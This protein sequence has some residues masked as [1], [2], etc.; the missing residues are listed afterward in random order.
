M[1]RFAEPSKVTVVIPTY[2]HEQFIIQ[3]L[4]SVLEQT[5]RPADIVIINDGSP[6]RTAE[7]L[8]PYLRYIRY[9]EQD[10]QGV[11][12]TVNRGLS[13]VRTDYVT[14]LASDDW[15]CPTAL[16]ALEL[17]LDTHRDIVLAHANRWEVSDGKR[18]VSQNAEPLGKYEPISTLI[19]AN[20]VLAPAVMVRTEPLIEVGPIADFP[21]CQDWAAYLQLALKGWKFF[22]I[23]APLGYYRRHSGNTTHPRN[24]TAIFQ[25]ETAMLE[26]LMSTHDIPLTHRDALRQSLA[27]RKA[28]GA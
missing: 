23:S 14:V 12:R 5:H 1:I 10:N 21:F 16:E 6:D 7:V 19:S 11:S 9:F 13:L 20:S 18:E 25:D 22:R 8:R 24:N 26:W 2:R 3:C 27:Q 15:L 17:V 28:A 4:E